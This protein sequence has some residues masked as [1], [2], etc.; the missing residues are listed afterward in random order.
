VPV[1]GS[2]R[3]WCLQGQGDQICLEGGLTKNID[4]KFEILLI[5]T[6]N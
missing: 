3:G 4:D 2:S 6:G 5:P 1:G